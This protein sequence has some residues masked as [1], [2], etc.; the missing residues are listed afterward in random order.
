MRNTIWTE[1]HRPKRL[2]EMALPG[3]VKEVFEDLLLGRR[4][5]PNLLLAGP[6]GSGKTSLA[7]ILS[8]HLVPAENVLEMNA[9]SD[10]EIS[11]IRGKIKMF[12]QSKTRLG[13]IKVII[14][15]ECDY[16]TPDAQHC[17][18][19]IIEDTQ[20]ST[21]F[22]F[23]T[24]YINR[25]IDPIKSRLVTL[26]IPGPSQR[27][28]LRVLESIRDKESLGVPREDLEYILSISSGDMRKAIVLL[29]TVGQ[30]HV[31]PQEYRGLIREVAGVVPSEAIDKIFQVSTVKEGLDAAEYLSREGYPALSV[32]RSVSERLVLLP[33]KTDKVLQAFCDLSK[34]EEHIVQGGIEHIQLLP[35]ILAVA[36]VGV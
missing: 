21:R 5:L 20:A 26:S 4:G 31:P 30:S 35:I 27:T 19:R 7:L 8:T 10:R 14:M 3:E 1:K 13:E 28:S 32:I 9:S 33:E 22:I 18:R 25:V 11:V 2:E 6:P 15:D 23:I 29:Q 16:L 17:L 24:N 36:H 12:A 34:Y